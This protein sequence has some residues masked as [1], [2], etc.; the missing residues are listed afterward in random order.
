MKL[1]TALVGLVLVAAG[2]ES[3]PPEIKI[4]T[5][6]EKDQLVV[7]ELN[8]P[9]QAKN[10]VKLDDHWHT[11][12]LSVD[13]RTRKFLRRYYGHYRYDHGNGNFSQYQSEACTD[14]ITEL[15]PQ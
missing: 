5:Q 15:M 8:L 6:E 14:T 4:V 12:E 7:T 11:F 10:V 9:P 2:C 3:P 13:G 1:K